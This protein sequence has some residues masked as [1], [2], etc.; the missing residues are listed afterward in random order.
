MQRTRWNPSS[1]AR[2]RQ[3]GP[4]PQMRTGTASFSPP[5]IRLNFPSLLREIDDVSVRIAQIM[6]RERAIGSA[7]HNFDL[8]L[9]GIQERRG[10]FQPLFY[11]RD[12]LNVKTQNLKPFGFDGRVLDQRK[13]EISI[14]Q[15]DRLGIGLRNVLSVN[16]FHVKDKFVEIREP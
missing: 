16:L 4:P 15:V 7:P 3:T 8:G 9:A 11:L 5:L 14:R 10:F 13:T 12:T 6:L 1:A 2:A